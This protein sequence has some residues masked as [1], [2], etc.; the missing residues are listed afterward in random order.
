MITEILRYI[1]VGTILFFSA[2]ALAVFIVAC[3]FRQFLRYEEMFM[4]EEELIECA[5][6]HNKVSKE[7][8]K[9]APKNIVKQRVSKNTR[10]CRNC[11]D[12]VP[13]DYGKDTEHDGFICE[14]CLR[15]GFGE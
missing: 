14:Q 6:C 3:A 13:I 7:K 5:K 4:E 10:R 15:D 2:I 8:I 11:K 1:V 9:K 12:V